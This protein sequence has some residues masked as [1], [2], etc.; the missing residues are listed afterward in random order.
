MTAR[1]RGRRTPSGLSTCQAMRATELVLEGSPTRKTS[2]SVRPPIP[3]SNPAHPAISDATAAR[4]IR[5]ERISSGGFLAVVEGLSRIHIDSFTPHSPFHE[6]HITLLPSSPLP[7]SSASLLPSLQSISSTLLTTLAAT[8][9]LPPLLSRRLK[10]F[11]SSLSLATAPPLVDVLSASIPSSS[12]GLRFEDK[13]ALLAAVDPVER[14]ELGIEILGKVE[15]GLRLKKRIGDKVEASL[16]RRQ[17]E[18]L[19]LQQLNAIKQELEELAAKDGAGGMV[20]KAGGQKKPS[21]GGDEDDE[22]DDLAELEKKVKEKNWTEEARKVAM[23][24]LK[25]LKKS[26][27]QGAEHGVIRELALA[28]AARR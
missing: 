24:E 6:A 18:Y 28:S 4:I 8:A 11:V 17:R 13:L 10:A 7:V 25:R 23:K 21:A 20:G 1:S 12:I 3:L 19:L 27:P 5:L 9:P 16:G 14:V 15:E 22:E 2:S 26:P